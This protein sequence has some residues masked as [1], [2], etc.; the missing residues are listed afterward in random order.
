MPTDKPTPRPTDQPPTPTDKPTPKPTAT[1]A[2]TPIPSDKPVPKPQVERSVIGPSARK[3]GTPS[4]CRG[5]LLRS[6]RRM[7]RSPSTT[8]SSATTARAGHPARA[9]SERKVHGHLRGHEADADQGADLQPDPFPPPRQHAYGRSSRW[10][11][12][13]DFNVCLYEETNKRVQPQRQVQVGGAAG[14]SQGTVKW[15]DT[16]A[17]AAIHLHWLV[18]GVRFELR[19]RPRQG[20][21]EARRRQGWPRQPVPTAHP[22]RPGGLGDVGRLRQA[23]C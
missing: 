8:F 18:G 4:G 11:A 5:H 13:A 9:I 20:G 16:R 3:Q 12:T 14:S 15:A 23:R 10:V 21:A 7:R 17:K 19:T 1:A 22:G 6:R 2:P